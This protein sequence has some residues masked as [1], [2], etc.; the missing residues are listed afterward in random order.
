MD[1]YITRLNQLVNR[2]LD[3]LDTYLA[4]EGYFAYQEDP[5]KKGMK[6][7]LNHGIFFEFVPFTTEH[8]DEHG[9]IKASASAYTIEQVQEGVDYALVISTNAGLWRYLIGDLVRFTNAEENEL[10]ISGRIRQFLSL[11]GEHLSLENINEALLHTSSYFN[12]DFPEFTIYADSEKQCHCWYLG[13]KQNIDDPE[14][15]IKFLDNKLREA[16][17][18]YNSARKYSLKVPEMKIIL[19]SVF[20]SYMAKEKKLGSQNK[21]P[22]VLNKKQS[23]TWLDFINAS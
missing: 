5:C 10:V 21:M 9:T 7:L 17:D 14:A 18:D 22:R 11:C 6:L 13:T 16:N 20:Y 23:K 1:P 4:S 12:V 15:L 2:E 8:F 3:L 19:P